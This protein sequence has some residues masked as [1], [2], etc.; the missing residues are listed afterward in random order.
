VRII[1]VNQKKQFSKKQSRCI[2][3]YITVQWN[4]LN[5]LSKAISVSEQIC[6]GWRSTGAYYTAK[7]TFSHDFP[8]QVWGT[9]YTNVRIIFEFLR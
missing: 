7:L 3:I 8:I 1:H 4:E 6:I 5:L 9:Y 2:N